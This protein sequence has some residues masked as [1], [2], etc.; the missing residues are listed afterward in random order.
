LYEGLKGNEEVYRL[1]IVL[2]KEGYYDGELTDVYTRDIT[3]AVT[4]F[5]SKRNITPVNGIVGTKTR[6]DLNRIVL[7]W[8]GKSVEQVTTQKQ[9]AEDKKVPE[10][11]KQVA[12]VKQPLKDDKT[13]V[14]TPVKKNPLPCLFKGKPLKHNE[15]IR[16]FKYTVAPVG[17]KCPSSIRRCIDGALD[18]DLS[19]R[20]TT[21]TSPKVHVVDLT[22]K[23]TEYPITKPKV[24]DVDEDD[25]GDPATPKTKPKDTPK[26]D[27]KNPLTKGCTA[28]GAQF[29][30]GAT[31]Q[32][33]I[34]PGRADPTA[35]QC[36]A[37]LMPVYK[38]EMSGSWRCID[39]CQFNYY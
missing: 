37:A 10:K 36:L 14:V 17:G 23:K 31:T 24:D 16:L 18:G 19:Y 8:I 28:G 29:N 4:A 21:C 25:D 3:K 1:S 11:A 15:K 13:K 12:T 2:K 7:G 6:Y 9:K 27:P 33:C 35:S 5:Q 30:V 22:E 26:T 38:C 20:H 32:G 34:G 39:R